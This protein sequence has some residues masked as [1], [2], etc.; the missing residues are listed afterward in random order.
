MP[1]PFTKFFSS[2]LQ[3]GNGRQE[4]QRRNPIF[5]TQPI[6]FYQRV[7][8]TLRVLSLKASEAS[9]LSKKASSRAFKESKRAS[10]KRGIDAGDGTLRFL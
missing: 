5:S 10:E 1:T 2:S 9:V 8:G 3:K 6:I 7:D 4:N